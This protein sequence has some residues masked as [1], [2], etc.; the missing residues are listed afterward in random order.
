MSEIP[1]IVRGRQP[2]AFQDWVLDAR[3]LGFEMRVD[4]ERDEFTVYVML[5]PM[6]RRAKTALDRALDD[7]CEYITATH[8]YDVDRRDLRASGIDSAPIEDLKKVF[9]FAIDDAAAY[10]LTMAREALGASRRG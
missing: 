10:A 4:H 1:E 2:R 7:D 5:K 9:A 3:E 6:T 8:C